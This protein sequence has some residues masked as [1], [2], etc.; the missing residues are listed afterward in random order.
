MCVDFRR[1]FRAVSCDRATPTDITVAMC[2]LFY[3]EQLQLQILMPSVVIS[4]SAT[5][6]TV[7]S[8]RR[9]YVILNNNNHNHDSNNPIIKALA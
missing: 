7:T 8:P 2:S 3:N 9:S 1:T 4:I 5:S 6:M